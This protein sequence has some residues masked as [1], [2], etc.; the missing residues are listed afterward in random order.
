MATLLNNNNLWSDQNNLQT[1]SQAS[2]LAVIAGAIRQEKSDTEDS[3]D[4]QKQIDYLSSEME[5]L[6]RQMNRMTSP[7]RR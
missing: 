5:E 1:D 2:K 3:K 4:M 7:R 6:K